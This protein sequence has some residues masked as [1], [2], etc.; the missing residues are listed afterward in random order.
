M[1]SSLRD[2]DAD[3]A[4]IGPASRPP[5]GPLQQRA[6]PPERGP[7]SL[8][9]DPCPNLLCPRSWRGVTRSPQGSM[10]AARAQSAPP[11]A[12]PNDEIVPY[13]AAL[14]C[15]GCGSHSDAK[16]WGA[17]AVVLS[18]DR[19]AVLRQRPHGTVCLECKEAAYLA[20]LPRR[21]RWEE[22]EPSLL[23]GSQHRT[24]LEQWRA[25]RAG[26]KAPRFLAQSASQVTNMGYRWEEAFQVFTPS[27]LGMATR[28]IP[29][30]TTHMVHDAQG[31][32]R[33]VILVKDPAM[34]P[35]IIMY[36]DVQV[37]LQD[38]HLRPET[39]LRREQGQEFWAALQQQA[40][41][42]QP[43]VATALTKEELFTLVRRAGG[44]I[45][46]NAAGSELGGPWPSPPP[47]TAGTA[48]SRA[49]SPRPPA[50]AD[51][52]ALQDSATAAD[53]QCA[54]LVLDDDAAAPARG[55]GHITHEAATDKAQEPPHSHLALQDEGSNAGV[56][57][58]KLRPTMSNPEPPAVPKKKPRQ[59][60]A[61][62]T[63]SAGGQA[64]ASEALTVQDILRGT[65]MPPG[66]KVLIYRRR[67]QL[68]SLK[69]S[70]DTLS[71]MKEMEEIEALSA[72]ERLQPAEISR[73]ADDELRPSLGLVLRH[74]GG[75]E[76]LPVETIMGLIRRRALQ[77]LND[78]AALVKTL[79]P[80]GPHPGRAAPARA[81]AAG[82]ADAPAADSSR[83]SDDDATASSRGEFDPYEPALGAAP[84]IVSHESRLRLALDTFV[85]DALATY[86]S[87]KAE[88]AKSI[89]ALVPLTLAA[90]V[91]R[92]LH[93]TAASLAQ[94]L[95]ATLDGMG[96]I[97]QPTAVN[98]E[99]LQGLMSLTQG[100]LPTAAALAPLL[101]SDYWAS[102]IKQAW[103][104]AAAESLAEPTMQELAAKLQA[105]ADDAWDVV[106]QKLPKWQ[107]ELRSGATEPL[108]RASLAALERGSSTLLGLADSTGSPLA[109]AAA[110][111]KT[112]AWLAKLEV[113]RGRMEWL[114]TF[115]PGALNDR[116]VMVR[117]TL[118][119]ASSSLKLQAAVELARNLPEVEHGGEE[120]TTLLQ[121]M[122]QAL[123]EC[124]GLTA[125]GEEGD[126]L[127]QAGTHLRDAVVATT[128]T[129]VTMVEA[130]LALS[131]ISAIDPSGRDP[132][133]ATSL[134]QDDWQKTRAGLHLIALC[135]EAPATRSWTLS[136]LSSWVTSI[137]AFQTAPGKVLGN[138]T[139]IN[140]ALERLEQ[141]RSTAAAQVMAQATGALTAALDALEA[142]AGGGSAGASWKGSLKADSPWELVEKEA[143]YHLNFSEA[144]GTRQELDGLYTS[145]R[146]ALQDCKATALAAGLSLDPELPRRAE[147]AISLAYV[148]STE[149][150]LLDVLL[151]TKA[152]RRT[153]KIQGW[154]VNM[155]KRHVDKDHI[156]PVLWA[157][158]QAA[159]KP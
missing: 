110:P 28:T 57:R 106:Q 43:R 104:T 16:P 113:T 59:P 117:T 153:S 155:A 64:A 26:A 124:R 100:Q 73:L 1:L 136:G 37:G 85:K 96:A 24:A 31:E 67:Q 72:A 159:M 38:H 147:R 33:E 84:E 119:E 138:S 133:P 23:T 9:A 15:T 157:R 14:T 93:G 13:E 158:A 2:V 19:S 44:N 151:N 8:Q 112:Q 130:E 18:P 42:S 156:Q 123:H 97:V 80:F 62:R 154:V 6:P 122:Q 129:Q 94:E 87:R 77:C 58:G 82:S 135:E 83:G 91:P 45:P 125:G 145:A 105:G 65:T 30:V 20:L 126:V 53:E 98:A 76:A 68:P 46:G 140:A 131:V 55:I 114:Q 107:R 12:G 139:A 115:Q 39:H 22:F 49:Q 88:G 11:R 54:E 95:R 7:A 48:P 141:T 25:L 21:A 27:D 142:R 3:V 50:G 144:G 29:G 69:K 41:Q 132:S 61:A 89:A 63:Q 121:R 52:A 79:W 143:R 60:R 40:R 35:R 102:R 134:S 70:A 149:T 137:Q 10:A 152:D 111:A 74:I 90:P 116:L 120:Y 81:V 34:P 36:H 47:G 101:D 92:S 17:Q 5:G 127:L 109:P 103:T 4:A 86:L 66:P 146:N 150:A 128:D 118:A 51:T 71:Y 78:P 75:V 148:T 56:R 99:Q 108:L 32:S